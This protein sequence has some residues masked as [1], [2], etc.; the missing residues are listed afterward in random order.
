MPLHEFA[1]AAFEGAR[2]C[3]SNLQA[4]ATQDATETHLNVMA[5]ALH[6]LACC[7]QCAQ[8]LC[9]QRLAMHSSEPSETWQQR[10]AT[11]V[12]AVSLH[13]HGL[14]WVTHVPGLQW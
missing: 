7:Q 4:K 14:E 13:R 5:F 3:R 2:R 10:Y 6:K 11:R 12:L 9:W 8:F 1:N